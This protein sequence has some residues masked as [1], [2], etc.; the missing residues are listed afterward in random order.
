MTVLYLKEG[1]M[2]EVIIIMG[3]K[4][5]ST[6]LEVA[7]ETLCE[8]GITPGVY[9][10]S[11]HRAPEALSY[12]IK[13]VNNSGR[14][15]VIIAAAGMSAALPGVIAS[16]TTIPVIGVPLSGSA[17]NGQ[18]ALYSI[19]QMPP[20]VPVATMGIDGAKNAALFALRI[21]GTGS[22]DKLSLK[23]ERFAEKQAQDNVE[24]GTAVHER[25]AEMVAGYYEYLDKEE[26]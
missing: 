10:I 14:T 9:C 13:Q 12:L 7:V 5:D 1:I 18:D 3:S 19:A 20:G 11:A 2:E 6:K 15:H 24:V 4:S 22:I 17:L 23:L 25:F 21:L 26:N 8:F 16:Q